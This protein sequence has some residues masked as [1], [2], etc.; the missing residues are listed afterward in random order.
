MKKIVSLVLV[1]VLCVGML[2]TVAFADEEMSDTIT[3]EQVYSKK[4]ENGLFTLTTT[5]VDKDGWYGG[6]TD[7]LTITAADGLTIT[8]IDA[9]IG[10]FSW[11]YNNVGVSGSAVKDNLPS[12][13]GDIVTVS[14]INA[15]EFSFVGGSN[16]AQFKNITVY[17]MWPHTHSYDANNVCSVCHKT[18]TKC[19]VEGH[20]Y[21]S[22]FLCDC[23][24]EEAPEGY[25]PEN[26]SGAVGAVVVE[27]P[28]GELGLGSSLSQ[29]NMT[30]V[31]SVATLA[32]GLVGGLLIG[33]KK[34]PVAANGTN[35]DEE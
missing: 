7:T 34:K 26:V 10:Y 2:S 12:E 4:S 32:L 24:G 25:D 30:I 29:G 27:T 18:K 28:E 13:D 11:N 16:F 35:S 17:Y 3:F 9:V 1:L 19:D 20:N 8:R 23:C 6:D 22:V 5:E 14:N 15:S 31:C 21:V 33:K